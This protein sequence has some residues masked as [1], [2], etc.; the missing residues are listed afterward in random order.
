MLTEQVLN[1]VILSILWIIWCAFHSLL[2]TKR[3]TR[4][5]ERRLVTYAP[6]H[7]IGYNCVSMLSFGLLVMFGKR[8]PAIPIYEFSNLMELLRIGFFSAGIVLF[9]VGAKSYDLSHFMG[10][11]QIFS[12][13]NHQVLSKSGGFKVSGIAKIIRHPWYLAAFFVIWSNTKTIHNTDLIT[14]IVFSLYLI[15]GTRLEEQKLV[16]E[17]GEVYKQYQSEVSMFIPFKWLKSLLRFEK[18]NPEG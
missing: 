1:G 14:N 17:L 5:I 2:I 16:L 10:F 3:F 4:F 6:Y 7:R 15:L 9:L 8:L 11:R 18:N 13:H 12:G